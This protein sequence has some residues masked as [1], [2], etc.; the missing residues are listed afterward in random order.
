MIKITTFRSLKANQN[1]ENS[2]GKPRKWAYELSTKASPEEY[3]DL[4]F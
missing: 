3:E 1:E 2:K 4:I